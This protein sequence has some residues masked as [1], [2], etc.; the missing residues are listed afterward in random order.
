M[1]WQQWLE[2]VQRILRLLE[3]R[4]RALNASL[5]GLDSEFQLFVLRAPDV[6]LLIESCK[7]GFRFIERLFVIGRVDLEQQIALLY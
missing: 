1:F 2:A 4:A 5:G 6:D 3:L 7:R